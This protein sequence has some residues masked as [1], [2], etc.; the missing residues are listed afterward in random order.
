MDAKRERE[1]TLEDLLLHLNLEE[2]RNV[3]WTSANFKQ[4][5]KIIYENYLLGPLGLDTLFRA[6][7]SQLAFLKGMDRHRFLQYFHNFIIPE[8][9][10]IVWNKLLANDHLSG[11][12]HFETPEDEET[13]RKNVLQEVS[14]KLNMFFSK[15]FNE[16]NKDTD[17]FRL[18]IAF[19]LAIHAPP[20]CKFRKRGNGGEN[21]VLIVVEH[22]AGDVRSITHEELVSHSTGFK[23]PSWEEYMKGAPCIMYRHYY[24]TIS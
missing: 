3:N 12:T 11:F 7:N 8:F 14:D 13:A 17:Y 20:E 5:M 15:H 23:Y 16:G 2:N 21:D 18:L 10:Q 6:T 24:F 4:V 9:G 1:T 22:D 19:M